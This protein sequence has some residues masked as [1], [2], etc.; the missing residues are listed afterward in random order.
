MSKW[1][2]ALSGEEQKSLCPKCGKIAV[3]EL[4]Y[5]DPSVKRRPFKV[6]TLIEK[7]SLGCVKEYKCEA[8]GNAYK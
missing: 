6:E 1:A 7:H 5:K 8:C 2:K 3:V 4:V